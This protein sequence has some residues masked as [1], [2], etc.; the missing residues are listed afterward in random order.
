MQLY[1][2]AY[3][4]PVSYP[5]ITDGMMAVENDYIAAIGSAT[6][7]MQQYPG[8]PVIDLGEVMLLPQAAKA[9]THLELTPLAELG[10]RPHWQSQSGLDGCTTSRHSPA[11]ER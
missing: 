1:K 9:Q 11:S 3:I 4:Y 5:P 10:R 6:E 2:A 8:A 7:V